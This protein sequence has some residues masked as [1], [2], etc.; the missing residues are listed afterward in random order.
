M[1]IMDNKNGELENYRKRIDELDS[2]IINLLAE[3]ML[4]VRGIARIKRENHLSVAN[5]ERERDKRL[6]AKKILRNKGRGEL[7]EYIE[8]IYEEIFRV[9]RAY[10]EE[11]NGKI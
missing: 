4:L 6:A 11:L 7:S 8:W 2:K 5:M 1:L 3:R 9:S 10:Q